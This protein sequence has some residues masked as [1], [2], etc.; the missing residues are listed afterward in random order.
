MKYELVQSIDGDFIVTKLT[1]EN[2]IPAMEIRG[3]ELTS[4]NRNRSHRA[5]LQGQ[6][7]FSG[8][9]GPMYG[10]PG[11]IR[12]ECTKANDQLSA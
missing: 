4:Y 5:E 3:Y 11:V 2:L 9:C 12:Y 7:K 6:P 1:T 8:L 10:G